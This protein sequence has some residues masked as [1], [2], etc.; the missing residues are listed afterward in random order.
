MLC[1][2]GNPRVNFSNVIML[3]LNVSNSLIW[4]SLFVIII[5]DDGVYWLMEL[6]VLMP[7]VILWLWWLI[8]LTIILLQLGQ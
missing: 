3:L 8:W 4:I 5:W 6:V 2:P 1:F 7:S